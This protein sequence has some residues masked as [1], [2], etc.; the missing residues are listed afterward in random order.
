MIQMQKKKYCLLTALWSLDVSFLLSVGTRKAAYVCISHK[1]S[2]PK[3]YLDSCRLT[4]AR[5]FITQH[6]SG[7]TSLTAAVFQMYDFYIFASWWHYKITGKIAFKLRIF[8]FLISAAFLAS[9]CTS[10][11][12][13]FALE[14]SIQVQFPG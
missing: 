7:I 4:S 11:T 3:E 2:F 13:C 8:N 10:V 6:N 1:C 14:I 9:G 5:N 12:A